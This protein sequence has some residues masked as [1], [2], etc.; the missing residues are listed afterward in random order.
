VAVFAALAGGALFALVA[1]L[2]GPLTR[3]LLGAEAPRSWVVLAAADVYLGT[4]AFVPLNLLRIEE[5]PGL[6]SAFSVGRHAANAALKV[7]LVLAG[8][9][10]AGVLWSDLL[11]TGLFAVA[12]LPRLRG[13]V[14][15]TFSPTLLREALAFGL[16]KVPHGLLVQVQ[17]LADRKILDLFVA[18]AEVGVY[19]MAYNF[20]QGVKLASSAFEPAW[21]PF[22]Y[23]EVR[24]PDAPR[25][26]ARVIS[27]AFAAFVGAG[28]AVAVLGREL[29]TLMTTKNPA[30]REGAPVIPVVA[31]A[32]V[33]HGVFL[34][35]S[36]GIGIARQARYYPLVTLAAASAN[37]AGNFI[38]IPRFGMMGAA[39]ATVLSYAVM[40]LVGLVLS[41]RLYPIPFETGRLLRLAGA[42]GLA[43]AVSCFA[44]EAVGPALAVKCA[45]LALFAA[46]AVF[47]V[48]GTVFARPAVAA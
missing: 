44:P 11:A 27:P 26:L 41:R 16:P 12:L 21:G 29:L 32:Y 28:L 8:L 9:G 10:V 23:A 7:W 17:N 24:R 42:A 18:R 13:R 3:L 33:L 31:A 19:S 1:L 30:F 20:G 6:F 45:L 34:L 47:E 38:L 2:A 48:R 15:W 39:W 36:V 14:A 25:T 5:R 46:Y 22:I 35:T 4:F 43:F 40:A 37:V